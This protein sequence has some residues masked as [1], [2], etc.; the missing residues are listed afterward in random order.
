[1][2]L[3]GDE[4][5]APGEQPAK[6]EPQEK[7]ILAAPL[8]PSAP[9]QQ[10]PSPKGSTIASTKSERSREDAAAPMGVGATDTGLRVL[11]SIGKLSCAPASFDAPC[12]DVRCAGVL[13][14]LPALL[15][16]GLLKH[17]SRFFALPKGYYGLES[18]FLLLAFMALCRAQKIEK[19]RYTPPGEWGKL[20]GLDRCPEAKTLRQKI[21][22]L[23]AGGDALA[24]AA[25]LC[26]EWMFADP[27]ASNVLF[28]D[29]HCRVYHGAQTALPRHY[30]AREKLCLRA[31]T[32]YWVH[33]LDG[34][35]LFKVNQAVDPG[36]IKTLEEIIVPELEMLV[37]GQPSA[38]ELAAEPLRQRF[39]IVC[40]RE[41][42]SPGF[43]KRMNAKRIAT[44]TYLK[45]PG[46]P[47]PEAEFQDHSVR[48]LNGNTVTMRLAERG[49]LLGKGA[50]AIWT[51]EVR[52]LCLS[53]HQVSI[54]ST[55]W[56]ATL[57]QIVA[58]QFGRW[59][60]ENFFKYARAHFDL[61]GLIDY[62]L[63]AVE[64]T[65][66]VI[67]PAWRELDG[68]VRKLAGQLKTHYQ[69]L[70]S[71]R[72]PGEMSPEKTASYEAHAADL[73]SGIETANQEL[74]VL[75]A[76]RR[77]QSKHITVAELP[78]EARFMKLATRSKHFVDT[79]RLIAYRAETA[80]AGTIK[81]CLHACHQE[82]ARAVARE[83][84]QNEADITPNAGAKTLTVTLHGLANPKHNAA[85]A[86]LCKALNE[87]AMTYP[88]TDLRLVYQM[89]SD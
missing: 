71:L 80:M 47:W 34:L 77:R 40:D 12:A 70:G 8:P 65:T 38:A 30:I 26:Q 54:V 74:D 69:K 67:N 45:S 51:R 61:D 39:R 17:S 88:G 56:L 49:A 55:E 33:G 35:P 27:A 31:T 84:C 2:A 75:K 37:P 14:A 23:C 78:E 64:D 9:Q 82:E 63:E 13:L 7:S 83:I 66:R 52:K 6:L 16:C 85:A 42:F 5:L 48:L 87:T 11:A 81:E 21:R 36:L 73:M 62:Q 60:Q 46:E 72:A 4:P 15:V 79:I 86:H 50:S 1:V 53:G 41:S 24:W 22:L 89:V 58:P 25:E 32:D 76:S 43:F 44:Q 68:E 29:G 3:D 10:I 57:A 19:L 28:V 18:I 20:L 59:Y